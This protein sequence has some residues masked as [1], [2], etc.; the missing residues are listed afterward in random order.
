[1][2]KFGIASYQAWARR[3]F[4]ERIANAE[5]VAVLET[6][7]GPP[8]VCGSGKTDRDL[9]DFIYSPPSKQFTYWVPFGLLILIY[10]IRN[11]RFGRQLGVSTAPYMVM[12]YPSVA[13]F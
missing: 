4:V 6:P 11:S 5:W 1:M 2:E 3:S 8:A 7:I 12:Y 13:P 10:Q 9:R